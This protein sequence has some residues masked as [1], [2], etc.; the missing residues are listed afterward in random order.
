MWSQFVTSRVLIALFSNII[1]WSV[2]HSSTWLPVQDK[3]VEWGGGGGGV[4]G[5]GWVGG[6]GVGGGVGGGGVGG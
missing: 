4:G 6:W 2:G 3:S 5:G 1:N